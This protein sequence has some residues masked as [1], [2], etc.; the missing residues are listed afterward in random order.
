MERNTIKSKFEEILVNRF[1]INP[2]LLIEDNYDLAL[3]GRVFGFSDINMVYLLL[4]TEK[5]FDVHVP[6][7]RLK[8]KGFFTVNSV[9]DTITELLQ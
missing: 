7:D 3:A 5:L 4:E 1:N 8:N 2:E 9:V 6:I